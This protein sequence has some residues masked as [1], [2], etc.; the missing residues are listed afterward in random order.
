MLTECKFACGK[1]FERPTRPG[2]SV[3]FLG[4]KTNSEARIQADLWANRL[5]NYCLIPVYFIDRLVG[6]LDG[7]RLCLMDGFTKG[8][9][10]D[11]LAFHIVWY[12]KN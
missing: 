2:I 5:I 9:S 6:P 8:V 4:P 11:S 1:V 12:S 3:V 10:F 7:R